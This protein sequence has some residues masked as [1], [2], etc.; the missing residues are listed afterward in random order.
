VNPGDIEEL[1]R[2][3]PIQAG[4]LFDILASGDRGLYV[5]QGICTLPGGVNRDALERAVQ[6]TIRRHPSLR[7]SFHW[8]GLSKPVQAVHRDVRFSLE[9]LD[10]RA[11]TSAAA[12]DVQ[13]E[14][15][16]RNRSE[17]FKLT[18]APLVRATLLHLRADLHRF[19]WCIHHLVHDAWST[20]IVLRELLA[21]YEAAIHNRSW[22]PPP[23]GRYRDYVAWWER[24]PKE[25]SEAFW[26]DYLREC[27]FDAPL[28]LGFSMSEGNWGH[29]ER[30]LPTEFSACIAEFTRRL[31]I[32]MHSL[33]A[34]VWAAVLSAYSGNTQAVFGS[35]SAG[36]PADLS[37]V[38]TITGVFINTLPVRI[39]C[40]GSVPIGAWLRA[41][42]QDRIA[43]RPHEHAPLHSIRQR[44]GVPHEKPLFRSILVLQNAF[45]SA[46]LI[47]GGSA[48]RIEDIRSVGR[49]SVPFTVRVT[50][51]EQILLEVLGKFGQAPERALEAIVQVLSRF[52]QNPAGPLG[53]AIAEIQK[54]CKPRTPR[55]KIV[56]LAP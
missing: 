25:E 26:R 52:M 5:E 37:D 40:T 46:R 16:E 38:E 56:G 53:D 19:V 29:I 54:A 1:Y 11:P 34:G 55:F 44:C 50:P 12:E 9:Y 33:I 28:P 10:L 51:G 15:L 31:G 48:L 24:K 21:A 17:A 39:D 14:L 20:G 23:A 32:T 7:T 18:E 22:A 45:N 27:P 4:M 42:H 43:A 49:S 8:E 35:V 30:L 41:I 3:S 2:L 47:P 13:R 36:R 6:A